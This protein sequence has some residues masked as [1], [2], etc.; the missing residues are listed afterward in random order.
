MVIPRGRIHER[1]PSSVRRAGIDVPKSAIEPT[2]MGAYNTRQPRL[3]GGTMLLLLA[4]L[5]VI[6]AV[7]GGIVVSKLL[8]FILVAALVVA[9]IEGLGRRS[10]V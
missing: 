6:I 1:N 4:L 9:V 3:K 7:A 10:S 2:P 5:L 8:F